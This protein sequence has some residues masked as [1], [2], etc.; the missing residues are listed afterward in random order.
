[1]RCRRPGSGC[2]TE[3]RAYPRLPG[4]RP[5]DG[6]SARAKCSTNRPNAGYTPRGTGARRALVMTTTPGL[7]PRFPVAGVWVSRTTYAD[8][9][10]SIIA[11][12]PERTPLTA[13]PTSVHGLT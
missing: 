6:P 2:R 3:R 13:G 9:T 10:A 8:A 11:A 1:P 7:A 5:R 12:A 4:I